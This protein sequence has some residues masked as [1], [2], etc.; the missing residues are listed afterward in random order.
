MTLQLGSTAICQKEPLP[1]P[2]LVGRKAWKCASR[3]A[4]F[5][6]ENSNLV[7]PAKE[8]Q[9]PRFLSEEIVVGK[10]LG[11]GGFNRVYEL[12]SI[13]LVKGTLHSDHASKIYTKQQRMLRSHVA[14]HTQEPSGEA[15]YVIKF[16][17]QETLIDSGRFVTG[18]ADLAVESKFLASL[19]HPNIIKLRGMSAIGTFGFASGKSM[20]YF[21]ILD[22]LRLTLED[23]LV[24][25]KQK[26]KRMLEF[27]LQR[28]FFHRRGKKNES[29]LA[30]RINVALDVASALQ[31]LHEK[32]VICKFSC[33]KVFLNREWEYCKNNDFLTSFHSQFVISNQI[34]LVLISMAL[35][36]YLTLVLPRN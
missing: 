25:W 23:L 16:L 21:L 26:A 14:T 7:D 6:S 32:K 29:F 27:S 4:R 31:Y 11:S 22:R 13:Q 9:I 3:A 28:S 30:D 12:E 34:I 10:L 1:S 8:S 15:K 20:G 2:S 33:L 36:N 17:S 18:A 5:M 35:S 24:E 19:E